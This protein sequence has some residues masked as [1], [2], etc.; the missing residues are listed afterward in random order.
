M[1]SSYDHKIKTDPKSAIYSKLQ[2]T[3]NAI[4]TNVPYD[5]D[6][7]RHALS[8]SASTHHMAES[9]PRLRVGEGEE[10]ACRVKASSSGSDFSLKRLEFSNGLCSL[11]QSGKKEVFSKHSKLLRRLKLCNGEQ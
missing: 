6:S 5:L 4:H 9:L 8:R 10:G 1:T 7:P 2:A 11:D 3:V